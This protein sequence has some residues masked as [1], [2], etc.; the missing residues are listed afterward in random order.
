MKTIAV[1]LCALFVTLAGVTRAEESAEGKSQAITSVSYDAEAKSLTVVFERG[2]YV[3]ADVPAEVAEALE[4]S[5]SQ[6]TYYNEHIK[7][8]YTSTKQ[9]E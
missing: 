6:G 5:E 3:Y 1:L 2:T 9:D 7:G 4:K 8:K